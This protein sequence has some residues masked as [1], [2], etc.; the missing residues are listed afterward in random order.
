MNPVNTI[1]LPGLDGTDRLLARFCELAPESIHA[2]V[3]SL[4]DDPTK[5]Y[6]SL[7]DHF[8]EQFRVLESCHLIAESFSGPLGILL[9][10]R[11]PDI[12]KR[13]TL[14]A[15]FATPPGPFLSRFVPWSL[16]FRLP[17]PSLIARHY[18]AGANR[19]L[20]DELK[21]RRTTTI[22]ANSC[23]EDALFDEC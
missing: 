7:C 8:F 6:D 9:A 2:S 22:P 23:A 5:N 19:L 20:I 16:V 12:I 3:C 15:T 13:L 14:V 4:P 1:I 18:F 17:M 21:N 11:L 10:H